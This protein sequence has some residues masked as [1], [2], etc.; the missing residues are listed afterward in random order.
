MSIMESKWKICEGEGDVKS[1]G[2][3]P[4]CSYRLVLLLPDES[5]FLYHEWFTQRTPP[6]FLLSSPTGLIVHE[7]PTFELSSLVPQ[8]ASS[9]FSVSFALEP[10][11]RQLMEACCRL[12]GKGVGEEIRVLKLEE[13]D[14]GKGI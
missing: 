2:S 9:L 6:I 10:S 12:S 5:F 7:D 8:L 4:L 14:K 11:R 3:R 13:G 1:L